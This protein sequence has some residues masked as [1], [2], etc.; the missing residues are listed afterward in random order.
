ML[1]DN[2]VIR[3]EQFST[4]VFHVHFDRKKVLPVWPILIINVFK[5]N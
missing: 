1:F 5:K 2:I 4:A 3:F